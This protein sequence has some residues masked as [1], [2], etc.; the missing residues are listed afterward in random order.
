M[1]YNDSIKANIY[2][3]RE[4]N[5]ELYKEL[6]KKHSKSYYERNRDVILERQRKKRV[7]LKKQAVVA[8]S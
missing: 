6:S 3:W 8:V 7:E 1:T 5:A 4:H 2:K